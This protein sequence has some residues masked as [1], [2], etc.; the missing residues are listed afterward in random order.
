MIKIAITGP[1]STGKST[2]SKAL[3]EHF[4]VHWFPEYARDYLT[5]REGKY[6]YDDLKIIAQEQEEKRSSKKI[7]DHVV[8]YDTENLVIQI[9]AEYKYGKV[10]PFITKLVQRQ[11]FDHYFLASPEGM[12]WEYDPLRENPVERKALFIHYKS[13]VESHNF[14]HTILTGDANER[15]EKAINIT[16]ELLLSKGGFCV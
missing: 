13:A 8:F 4:Q 7:A 9:W 3:A 12:A 14:P 5:P 10:D 16:E 1:E 6:D 2:I 11:E 15:I